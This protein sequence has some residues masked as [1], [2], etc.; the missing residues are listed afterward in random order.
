MKLLNDS[1]KRAGGQVEEAVAFFQIAR[2]LALIALVDGF[3]PYLPLDDGEQLLDVE[4]VVDHISGG[5]HFCGE[6]A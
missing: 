4:E 1:Y 2:L 5:G 3:A 6:C